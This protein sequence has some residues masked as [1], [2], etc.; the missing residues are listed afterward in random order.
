MSWFLIL[1]GLATGL[2]GAA[3]LSDGF[4]HALGDPN[5]AN[6]AETIGGVALLLA[7]RRIG[8]ALIVA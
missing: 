2:L 1:L 6:I 3:L 5:T 4:V 8:H 7:T